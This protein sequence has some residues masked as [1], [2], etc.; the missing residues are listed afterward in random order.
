MPIFQGQQRQGQEVLFWEFMDCRAAR[1]GKWK[2]VTEGPERVHI[3]IPVEKGKAGWELYDMEADRCELND[4]AEKRI[5]KVQELNTLWN[6][7][8]HR[9]GLGRIS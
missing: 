7:W 6:R 9:C 1:K 4:L 3:G 5:Q 2:I 8:A